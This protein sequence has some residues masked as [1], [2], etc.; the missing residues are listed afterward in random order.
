MAD[1]LAHVP[2]LTMG[3]IRV[4]RLDRAATANL[5]VELA[6]G[7]RE[8]A[9]PPAYLT[10]ANGQVL[11]MAARDP[12]VMRMFTTA[13]LVSADGQPM[14]LMSRWLTKA[15]LPERVAT[16]DLFHDVA[17]RAVQT[18]LTFYMLG[19]SP[20]ENAAAVANVRRL[21]PDLRIV[22]AHHG[23]FGPEEERALVDAIAQLRPDFLWVALGVPREQAFVVRNWPSLRGV[24]VVK[25]SGGLFNFLSGTRSRAPDWMQRAGLEWLYRTALEPRRLLWRYATTNVHALHILLTQTKE[26]SRQAS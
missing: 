24:G 9:A 20:T 13:D 22:G 16:T 15:P 18:G 8:S 12:A 19:A 26:T 10:S 25:T 23:Y 5:M 1:A 2:A 6:L 7:R 3:R 4:A 17:R 14:V 11:S 21:Y